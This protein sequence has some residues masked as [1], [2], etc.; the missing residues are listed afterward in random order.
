MKVKLKLYENIISL[1]EKNAILYP[2]TFYIL[3]KE[4]LIAVVEY[5]FTPETIEDSL[6]TKFGW[7]FLNSPDAFIHIMNVFVSSSYINLK[8]HQQDEQYVFVPLFL[9]DHT[10]FDFNRLHPQS[11]II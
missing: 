7:I 5:P 8:W 9:F 1:L 11:L 2:K 4:K 6:C 10:M 3:E